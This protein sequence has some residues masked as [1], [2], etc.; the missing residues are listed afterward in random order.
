MNRALMDGLTDAAGF[1]AGGLLGFGLTHALG[2]DV[3]APGYSNAGI[4]GILLLGLSGG[5]GVQAAR[6]LRASL[7][8]K[9]GAP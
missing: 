5:L 3:F 4:A 1:V 2:M 8:K 9:R 6:R 7:L